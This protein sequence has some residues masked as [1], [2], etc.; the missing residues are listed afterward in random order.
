V[1]GS[2]RKLREEEKNKGKGKMEKKLK[3]EEIL[4]EG[5]IKIM[6]VADSRD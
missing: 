4:L 6:K 1:C 3:R 2:W 5:K